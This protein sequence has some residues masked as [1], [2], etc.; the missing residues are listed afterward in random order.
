MISVNAC[1]NDWINENEDLCMKNCVA[2]LSSSSCLCHIG[3]VLLINMVS[4]HL[5]TFQATDHKLQHL[6]NFWHFA[7]FIYVQINKYM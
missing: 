3:I 5:N 4:F 1:A 2:P 7:T 6:F